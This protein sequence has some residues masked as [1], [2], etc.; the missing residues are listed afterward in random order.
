MSA[1]DALADST[2][3]TQDSTSSGCICNTLAIL[4]LRRHQHGIWIRRLV[5]V[6][7]TEKARDF[8]PSCEVRI[9]VL[10]DLLQG[11]VCISCSEE[12]LI[13]DVCSW[14][15]GL[16]NRTSDAAEPWEVKACLA[17]LQ[18]AKLRNIPV[19][20][21]PEA[22]SLC[23]N[24]WCH[25]VLFQ[26]AKLQSPLTVMGLQPQRNEEPSNLL[27]AQA[28]RSLVEM[29]QQQSLKDTTL[30]QNVASTTL[31]YLIKPNAGGFGAGIERR[32]VDLTYAFGHEA[33]EERPAPLF[34]DRMV[35]FQT[36]HPPYKGKIY[37]V[38]FLW[39]KVQCAVVRSSSSSSTGMLSGEDGPAADEFTLGCVGGVCQRQQQSNDPSSTDAS[40]A[41]PRTTT[42]TPW[43]VPDDVRYEIEEQ[44]IPV[45]PADAHC[46]SVEFLS[47]TADDGS[48]APRLYFD[49]NL[50]STLPVEESHV[51]SGAKDPWQELAGEILKFCSG[52]AQS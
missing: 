17:V 5:E 10:E 30:P 29:Q 52:L 49:L 24:K 21:G 2:S 20:N 26:Q 41:S 1:H 11:P 36:Y 12:S 6:L 43:P 42:I 25:H 35:L 27:E 4:T 38:W 51:V 28:V 32:S 48:H 37:R 13:N 46:G 45:M 47:D 9:V 34:S 23:T 50:L 18:L 44:L 19:W 3:S 33:K 31:D 16:I 7:Q 39:G 40:S 22:Y 14:T 15:C 8:D